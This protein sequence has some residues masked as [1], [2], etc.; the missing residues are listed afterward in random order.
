M[1]TGNFLPYW[2][3][4]LSF[5]YEDYEGIIYVY[6]SLLKMYLFILCEF[7]VDLFRH[8]R[9]GHRVPL[10]MVVSTVWLLGVELRTSGRAVSAFS[11]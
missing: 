8:T 2:K 5:S 7:T 6:I 4:V 1:S 9:R 10:Q 3:V 11:H